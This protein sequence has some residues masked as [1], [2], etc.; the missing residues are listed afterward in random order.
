MRVRSSTARSGGACVA[1]SLLISAVAT[2]QSSGPQ[3]DAGS[4]KMLNSADTAFAIKAAQG[5]A[6]EVQLG[7][8]AAQKAANADVKAFGQ[9]MVE[10]HTK[11]G[12]NLKA[13]AAKENMTLPSS[14]DAKDQ[15]L[16]V[17]LQNE[18]GSQFDHDY[19][20]AMV[21]D[22]LEDVK[23]FEKEASKGQDRNIKDFAAQ[24]LPVLQS[25]LQKIR[26]IQSSLGFVRKSVGG[27]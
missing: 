24:T 10:D 21:K 7:Q 20:R 25:H 15:A 26:S 12:E 17:K 3:L 2:A 18:S 11:A 19:V 14:L 16:C 8:L 4:Q 22:H 1:F 23:E 6:A 9:Q 27:R 13:V 5:G